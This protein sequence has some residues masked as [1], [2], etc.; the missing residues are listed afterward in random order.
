MS[1]VLRRALEEEVKRRE[2]EWA[3]STMEEI[4]AKAA[5]DKP[6]SE[7]IREFRDSRRGTPV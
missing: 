2:I 7:V 3:L 1:E 5:L 4:S 6:S